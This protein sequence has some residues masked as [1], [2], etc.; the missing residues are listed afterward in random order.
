[1]GLR[2]E[3][4]GSRSGGWIREESKTV[5]QAISDLMN[6]RAFIGDA[7]GS[8]QSELRDPLLEPC[9]LL[10]L[11]LSLRPSDGPRSHL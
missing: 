2:V 7:F 5:L 1:M 10:P 4:G 6:V 8:F 11:S 3:R 9:V